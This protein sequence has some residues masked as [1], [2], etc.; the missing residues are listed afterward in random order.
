MEKGEIRDLPNYP[1]GIDGAYRIT[2]RSSPGELMVGNINDPYFYRANDGE[3]FLATATSVVPPPQLLVVPTVYATYQSNL[4]FWALT[5]SS[6]F[7]V[8]NFYFP[9]YA[10]VRFDAVPS[11]VTEVQYATAIVAEMT[12]SGGNSIPTRNVK[13]DAYNFG[14]ASIT[15]YCINDVSVGMTITPITTQRIISRGVAFAG[16]PAA[17]Q[18]LIFLFN[19]FSPKQAFPLTGTTEALIVDCGPAVIKEQVGGGGG[20]QAFGLQ[21]WFPGQSATFNVETEFLFMEQKL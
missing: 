1:Y 7:T 21:L 5:F 2:R 18:E 13:S 8:N 11:G 19:S 6:D 16:A 10:K 3:V 12:R 9:L 20:R 14:N 17:N 15:P 4:W